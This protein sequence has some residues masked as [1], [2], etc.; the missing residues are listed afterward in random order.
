MRTLLALVGLVMVLLAPVKSRVAMLMVT[1]SVLSSKVK[2]KTTV[3]TVVNH[4]YAQK[5]GNNELE[6]QTHTEMC[7]KAVALAFHG[8]IL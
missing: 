1:R 8:V 3:A 7:L 4:S 6:R 5:I 2:E